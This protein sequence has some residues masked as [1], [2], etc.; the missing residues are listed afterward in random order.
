MRQRI[1]IQ[2]LLLA[3]AIGDAFGAGVE[4]QDRNWVRKNVDFTKLV[5]ALKNIPASKKLQQILIE[6]YREWDY[7]DDTEMTIGTMKAIVSGEAITADSLVGFWK[8]EYE[9]GIERK[10][11]PRCGH[12]SMRW[13]YS[14]EMSIEQVRNFQ[15]NRPNPGNA[16]AMWAIPFGLIDVALI[17]EYVAINAVATHP[18][19]KA[20]QSS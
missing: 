11:F 18:N 13:F 7:T 19:L 3:F 14:G 17:N 16:P 5:N 20:I 1:N 4:F 9:N 10:G 12:S 8:K 15:R 6:N 2:D